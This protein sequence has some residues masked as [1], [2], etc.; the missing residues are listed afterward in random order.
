[1]IRLIGE[2]SFEASAWFSTRQ[3]VDSASRHPEWYAHAVLRAHNWRASGRRVV[4]CP[5][6]EAE[7]S[8]LLAAA[9]SLVAVGIN[10]ADIFT[11]VAEVDDPCFA[12]PN[13]VAG[14][15]HTV[16]ANLPTRE[17]AAA[18]YSLVSDKVLTVS[19]LD[20]GILYLRGTFGAEVQPGA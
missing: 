19:D 10:C 18:S 8:H 6:H 5:R 2:L 12:I 15:I 4:F 11:N 1:M 14:V 13:Y 7:R 9:S 20:K 3:T 16:L 17:A